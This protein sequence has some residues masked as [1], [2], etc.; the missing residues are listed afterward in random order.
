[1]SNFAVVYGLARSGRF[2]GLFECNLIENAVYGMADAAQ[3]IQDK[4]VKNAEKEW[5][6][7]LERFA[8]APFHSPLV[9][10]Y[11][12]GGAKLVWNTDRDWETTVQIKTKKGKEVSFQSKNLK[13]EEAAQYREFIEKRLEMIEPPSFLE[14]LMVANKTLAES[15]AG[16][17][18]G[19]ASLGVV[20]AAVG[21][22][23]LSAR[24]YGATRGFVMD[25]LNLQDKPKNKQSFKERLANIKHREEYKKDL[26]TLPGIES[27]MQIVESKKQEKQKILNTEKNLNSLLDR[28]QVKTGVAVSPE[29]QD[30][31]KVSGHPVL[32]E[33]LDGNLKLCGGKTPSFYRQYVRY[34]SERD[35]DPQDLDKNG[36]TWEDQKNITSAGIEPYMKRC[37]KALEMIEP[38]T[39]TELTLLKQLYQLRHKEGPLS[40]RKPLVDA[41]NQTLDLYVTEKQKENKDFEKT[42]LMARLND[43][44]K[45]SVLDSR[46]QKMVDIHSALKKNGR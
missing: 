42:N 14:K 39:K 45:Y 2:K 25:K 30:L 29:F 26:K 13:K 1:M 4:R 27:A 40:D 11:L 46:L 37:S 12:K 20:P 35:P 32:A 7:P 28:G 44:R 6:K 33:Y 31:V 36:G 8:D 3:R 16:K 5:K 21:V 34:D 18:A 43:V 22:V 24:A 19:V 9:E 15:K 10:N 23:A 17:I 41:A 38:P